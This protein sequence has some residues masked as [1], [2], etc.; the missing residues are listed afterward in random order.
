MGQQYGAC[1]KCERHCS[2]CCHAVF[3]LFLIEATYLNEQFEKLSSEEKKSALLRCDEADMGLK[4]LE[5]MLKEFEDDPHMQSYT[6]AKE[7]I[8]CPLLDDEEECILYAH[9][10]VTCRVY[11]I[12]TRIQGKARVCGKARF[13]K[14]EAYPV[15]DLDGVYRDLYLISKELLSITQEGN[16]EKASLMISISKALRTPLD[17]LIC[18]T[19]GSLGGVP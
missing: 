15:F 11:G 17:G 8:R 16:P 5:R 12:P 14:G 3:G 10:P 4:R 13:K 9:R 6:M 18:E 2:E 7:R 19:F 1:I